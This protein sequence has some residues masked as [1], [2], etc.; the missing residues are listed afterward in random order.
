VVE[1]LLGK[2]GKGLTSLGR[3][4]LIMAICFFASGFAGLSY[5]IC[6]I[7]KACLIFGATTFAVST[8]TAVFFGGLA[9]GSY[10][11]GR[12]SEKVQRP[13]MIYSLLEVSLGI[14]ALFNPLF[15]SWTEELYRSFYPVF[16]GSFAMLSLTRIALVTVVILPPTILMGA[17]LPLFCRYYVVSKDKISLSVALLYGLNTLGATVG[18]AVTGF[19]LIPSIGV[20]ETIWLAGIVNIIVGC[21]SY[22]VQSLT[23]LS[24]AP[25]S[26]SSLSVAGVK[27]TMGRD[28]III[29]GLFF[30]SGF[31][32][33]GNEVLFVR[34]LSLLIHNSV[35]TYTLTLTITLTG[36]VLG[37]VLISG[38]GDRTQRRA[39]IFGMAH[40]LSAL[41]I[42][43]LLMLPAVWWQGIMSKLNTPSHVWIFLLL[44]LLPAV[45][46]GIS[47]PIAIRMAFDCPSLAGARFG[48]MYAFNTFGGIIGS[49]AVGFIFLPHAGLQKSL[50][51]TTGLSILIGSSA[52]LFL[53]RAVSF[54]VR[55]A[56]IAF[57]LII[58]FAIPYA[59]G[60][61]LPT[62]FLHTEM[63][64]IVDF[65]EGDGANLAVTKF[66][67]NN[68]LALE[69]DR[70]WQGN[71]L[72]NQQI[73]AAHVPMLFHP[74]P[75]SVLVVGVGVGKTASRF[76][77]YDVTR[78][79]CVDIEPGLFDIVRMNFDSSWM[80]D[81]RVRLITEDGRNYINNSNSNY[82]VIS[83]EVGQTFRPG[84]SSFYTVDFYRH[85]RERLNRGGVVSQFIPINLINVAEFRSLVRTFLEVFPNS[86]LWY[87]S[88]ELLLIGSP[89]DRLILSSE[90]LNSLSIDGPVKKDLFY[91]YFGG[92]DFYLNRLDVFLAG[93]L[94]GPDSLAKLTAQ[95]Q[96][97]RDNLPT[98]EYLTASQGSTKPET[99]VNLIAQNLDPSSLIQ[100]ENL[101]GT[102][103]NKIQDIRT[104]YLNDLYAMNLV[105]LWT[106]RVER[107][108]VPMLRRAVDLSPYNITIR[109]LLAN[110][111]RQQG[112]MA[113]A[114]KN[115][116][117]SLR[118]DPDWKVSEVLGR[119]Y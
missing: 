16:M 106:D 33:L 49:L 11:F 107:Y 86:I 20:N 17:T 47:F 94:C 63:Q 21:I 113:E 30:L 5:E 44:L 45:L 46:S 80:N 24:D 65:R 7:R 90:R 13:L 114:Q 40:V 105:H 28:G 27:T 34:Y 118:I 4:N 79:D 112:Q 93:F 67:D 72:K 15:F 22:R 75:K 68:E 104:L 12:Y 61:R 103:L 70:M 74:D 38:I 95:A 111:L 25:N 6:W 52:W 42:W 29:S 66:T 89:S 3:K 55:T 50:L 35:Y 69:I 41:M 100:R 116:D 37:S 82:D 10:L 1:M 108:N 56:L 88:A 57:G 84:I 31:V 32:A 77:F 78:L 43:S 39:F 2:I 26:E 85:V 9:I 92:P 54:R 101:A 73:M 23:P 119:V 62:D 48:K 83:I 96:V 109:L 8:V 97:Y 14:V 18:C 117:E 81:R 64:E 53:E 102:T 19:G 58:W 76:L 99:I 59:S 51:L 87:N 60:T 36:I 98:L 71:N 115:Q 91:T 110:A